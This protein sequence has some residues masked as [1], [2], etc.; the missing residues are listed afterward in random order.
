MLP[1]IDFNWHCLINNYI[2]IPKNVIN[3]CIYYILN[4]LLRNL[5][6]D[7]TW[8]SCIFGSVKLTKNAD[9]DK[10]R[11]IGYGMGFDFRSKS[12]FTD[13]RMGIIAITFGADRSSSVHID[14][15]NKDILILGERPM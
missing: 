3:L 9:P 11:Y 6:P 5:N 10:Y 7:F 14:N 15:K 4:P 12:S 13:G 8:K 2:S 1:D